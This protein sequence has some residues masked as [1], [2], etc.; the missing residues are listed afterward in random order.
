MERCTLNIKKQHILIQK[1]NLIL[2]KKQVYENKKKIMSTE[3]EFRPLP[4]SLTIS[5][6]TIEGLGLHAVENIKKDTPLGISHIE[7][8]RFSQGY[9]RT[10]LGAFV[11]HSN[12]NNCKLKKIDDKLILTAI[13]NINVNEELTLNYHEN[14]CGN[15]I[16]NNINIFC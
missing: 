6:S 8:D 2:D 16:I 9:I 13:E 4:K 15:Y 12:D 1:T 3:K 11:N 5:K 7:D 10:A 14:E